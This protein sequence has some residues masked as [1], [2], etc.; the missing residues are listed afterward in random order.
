VQS[1][2]TSGLGIGLFQGKVIPV[3]VKIADYNG[4][5]VSDMVAQVFYAKTTAGVADILAQ[6]VQATVADAGNYM[7]YDPVADQY[8]LNWNI[9]GLPNGDYNVRVGT[10]EGECAVGHWNPVRIGKATK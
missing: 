10:D 1:T 3:K 5:P 8:I 6:A 4:A 7:R 9:N 2:A